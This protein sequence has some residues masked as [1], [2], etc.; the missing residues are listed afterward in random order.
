MYD[1]IIR[2]HTPAVALPSNA[3]EISIRSTI[4]DELRKAVTIINGKIRLDSD[5]GYQLA[6]AGAII[7]YEKSEWTLSGYNC[8]VIANKRTDLVER[9]GTFYVKPCILHAMLIPDK[10]D[11][12]PVWAHA[13]NLTYNG[14]GTATFKSEAGNTTGRVGIDFLLCHGARENRTINVS[15]LVRGEKS[16]YDYIVCDENNDDIGKLSELYPA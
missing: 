7:G 12:K 15:I 3:V 5:N 16:F 9:D 11:V 6:P 4:P 8:W 14:D 10:D 2:I 13:A 1:N